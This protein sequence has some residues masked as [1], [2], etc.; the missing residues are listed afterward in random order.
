MKFQYIPT[1]SHLQS[2][3]AH[4]WSYASS[5]AAMGSGASAEKEPEPEIQVTDLSEEEKKRLDEAVKQATNATQ[6]LDVFV[7]FCWI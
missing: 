1:Y 7:P 3:S 2:F 5:Q 6:M 4:N